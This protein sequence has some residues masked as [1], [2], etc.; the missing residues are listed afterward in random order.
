MTYLRVY[1]V[2]F[3]E[4]KALE[5]IASGCGNSGFAIVRLEVGYE[6]GSDP[7][8]KWRTGAHSW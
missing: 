8:G 7:S 1:A 3:L 6:P 5:G 2:L 4:E